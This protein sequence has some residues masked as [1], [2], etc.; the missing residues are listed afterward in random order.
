MGVFRL[1][2]ETGSTGGVGCTGCC[3]GEVTGDGRV[4]SIGTVGDILLLRRVGRSEFGDHVGICI[5]E[6]EVFAA[7]GESEA[8]VKFSPMT[9]WVL[10]GLLIVTSGLGLARSSRSKMISLEV[11]LA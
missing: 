9:V 8:G 3:F 4:R 2:G 11:S 10:V 6:G 1:G 5:H 7:G